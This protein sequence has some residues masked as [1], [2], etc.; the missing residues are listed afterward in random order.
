[1]YRQMRNDLLKE[2]SKAKETHQNNKM[3]E[4]NVKIEKLELMKKE[5]DERQR[6]EEDAQRQ[7]LTQK[8]QGNKN[9]LDNIKSY[10]VED[11]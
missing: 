7:K 4:L 2:E 10:S 11:I 8:A 9:F 5:K 6:M 3:S 1:M